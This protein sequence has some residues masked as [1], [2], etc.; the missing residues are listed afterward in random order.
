MNSIRGTPQRE[1][2]YQNEVH[3]VS[4]HITTNSGQKAK[5]PGTPEE[6]TAGRITVNQPPNVTVFIK[7]YTDIPTS[8]HLGKL[9]I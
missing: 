1:D 8:Y 4:P 7:R 6:E 9:S 2:P 3:R 5:V